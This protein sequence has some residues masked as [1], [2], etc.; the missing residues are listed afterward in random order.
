MSVAVIDCSFALAWAMDEPGR[1]QRRK[2][3]DQVGGMIAKA[4]G[5]FPLEAGNVI[6]TLTKSG[7]LGTTPERVVAQL[8]NFAIDVRPVSMERVWNRVLK[9]AIKHRLSVYDATYLDL[10]I[11]E[12]AVLVT[13]DSEL[14]S[15][16]EK[17]GIS[18][19]PNPENLNE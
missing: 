4:P 13:L 15:A 1:A 10:A 16:A 8:W 12:N 5:I 2:V 11:Q 6:A 19:L 3:L 7:K 18:F 14:A 17:E 9:L